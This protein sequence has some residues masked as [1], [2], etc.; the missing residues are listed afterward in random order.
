MAYG[1]ILTIFTNL[2]PDR[3]KLFTRFLLIF[4]TLQQERDKLTA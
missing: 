3:N 1:L 4:K 2:R